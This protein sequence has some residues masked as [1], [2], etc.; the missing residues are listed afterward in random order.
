M[1]Q[2]GFYLEVIVP[3][4]LVEVRNKGIDYSFVLGPSQV[5]VDFEI[6]SFTLDLP[7][8]SIFFLNAASWIGFS[9]SV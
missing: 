3:F 7:K 1:D 5:L 9:A 6:V 8:L 2:M 4:E